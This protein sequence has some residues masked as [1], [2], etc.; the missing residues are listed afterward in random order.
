MSG[1]MFA[2]DFVVR[3]EMPEGL[4]KQIEKAVHL[5]EMESYSVK[6]CA[7]RAGSRKMREISPSGNKNGTR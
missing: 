2:Y 6:K 1:L 5:V 3:S 4:Q 7:V